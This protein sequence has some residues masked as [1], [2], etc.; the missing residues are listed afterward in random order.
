MCDLA[1]SICEDLEII[2]KVNMSEWFDEFGECI[3][4]I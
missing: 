1:F 2:E 4:D 3:Y